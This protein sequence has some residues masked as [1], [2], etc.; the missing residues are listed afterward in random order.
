MHITALTSPC[1][2]AAAQARRPRTLLG[3]LVRSSL[4]AVFIT[5]TVTAAYLAVSTLSPASFPAPMMPGT[6]E[7][8]TPSAKDQA[9]AR[10]LRQHRCWSGSA[11]SDLVG[12]LPDHAVVTLPNGKT[13]Y[14]GRVLTGRALD[15]EILGTHLGLDVAAFCHD[16]VER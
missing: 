10:L 12:V 14:A 11:P 1:H 16:P 3:T 8:E 2:N 4:S 6:V 13:V 15:Q 5:L 9:V 7:V